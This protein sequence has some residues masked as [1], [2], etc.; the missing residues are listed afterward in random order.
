MPVWQLWT[1]SIA[2]CGGVLI[3]HGAGHLMD[4][5]DNTGEI[6]VGSL[7]GNALRWYPSRN[8]STWC[9]QLHNVPYV[10][11]ET[12][13][14]DNFVPSITTFDFN[15][16]VLGRTVVS[17]AGIDSQAP[18]QYIQQWSASVGKSLGKSTTLEAGYQGTRGLHLQ[19]AHLINNAPPG[20]GLIQ[21]RRPY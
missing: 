19:R 2:A 7:T 1:V 5:N 18:S 8:S 15:P 16:A 10:F 21:P 9:D 13:Q 20:P 14:S 12:N 4:V 3:G 17:F 6:F 11:P